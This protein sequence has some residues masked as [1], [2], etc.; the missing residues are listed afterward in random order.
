MLLFPITLLVN[1][2]G[3]VENNPLTEDNLCGINIGGWFIMYASIV[4][5]KLLI[6]IARFY[7]YKRDRREILSLFFADIMIMNA[8]MTGIFIQANL[9]YFSENNNC[10]LTN[11]S[12]IRPTYIFFC[13]LT[14]LGYLQ[15]IQCILLSC[16]IPLSGFLIY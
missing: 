15:F 1:K 14:A 11:D 8:L 10:M 4:A 12:L 3:I 6:T 2:V 9:L 7:S 16:Y 13:L 5:S